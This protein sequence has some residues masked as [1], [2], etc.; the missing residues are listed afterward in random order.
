MLIIHISVL[1]CRL[2]VYNFYFS[3]YGA[4]CVPLLITVTLLNGL[5]LPELQLQAGPES[6]Y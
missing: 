2:C 5:I 3:L 6:I 1:S 4:S